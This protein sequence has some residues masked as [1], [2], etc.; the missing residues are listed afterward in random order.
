[1]T[2]PTPGPTPAP[3]VTLAPASSADLPSFR[4]AFEAVAAERRWIGTEAPIDWTERGPRFEATVADPAWFVVL[5]KDGERVVGWVSCHDE[6]G[7]PVSLGMGIV[8]GFRSQGLGTQ[9]LAA[10]IG[11]ARHRGAHK[12]ALEAWPTNARAIGLYEK[13]GFEVEGRYRRHWRR[14]DG[15]LWDAVSMGLVL[16]EDAPGGPPPGDS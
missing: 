13:F 9:L 16:D 3:A 4:E 7:G 12:V 14:N 6:G 10:A 5:A 8:D 15:S 1:M 2:E 11:W